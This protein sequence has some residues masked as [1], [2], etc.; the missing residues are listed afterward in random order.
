MSEWKECTLKEIAIVNP[1]ESLPKG[2]KAKKV[3]MDTLIPFTKKISCYSIEEYNGGM[4]FRNGDTL[5][6]RIT[7]CLENGKTAFVDILDDNEVGFGSTEFIVLREKKDLSDKNFL[8]YF[9]M[10]P[11]FRDVAILSMTG[12]SGRQRVQIDVVE[13]HP[14]L[15]PPLPEQRAIASV[16]SSLDDKIDLLHRQNKTLEA[17]AETLFRQWFV[18]PCKDGLPEGW[19]EKPLE[20]IYLFE[21]GFEPGSNN[22]LDYEES[23]VIRFIRVGDMFDSNGNIFIKKELALKVCNETDLLMSFD[24]TVGRITF[25]LNGAYSSGIRKIYSK[26]KIYDNL[27]LKYLLFNSKDIQ[28]LINSHASGSVILHASSSIKYLTFNFPEDEQI[29]HFN[30]VINPIF[31]KILQNKIHIRT[32]EKLRDTLLPKL[33][34]GEVRVEY[35]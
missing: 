7:P 4:K 30:E 2:V 1:T 33:M 34:S 21:K 35:E 19:E 17:M 28:E 5:V 31:N 14:F 23:G 27:G 15:L 25:G 22:Y 11:D 20:E 10:S 16:L 24:G 8:Y 26:N 9:A 3:M 6:A 32:L 18:E 13:N 29:D 12:S